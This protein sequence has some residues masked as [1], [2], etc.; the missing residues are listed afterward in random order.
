MTG[1]VA[2][3]K[4]MSEQLDA[5]DRGKAAG[6]GAAKVIAGLFGVMALSG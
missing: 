3:L 5:L 2:G 6:E 4:S 1:A